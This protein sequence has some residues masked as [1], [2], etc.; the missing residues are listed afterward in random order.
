MTETEEILKRIKQITGHKNI[1]NLS[2]K[3]NVEYHGLK[4]GI[5]RERFQEKWAMEIG[6]R[7]KKCP[8]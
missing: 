5:D 7:Y 3:I 2:R 8:Y 6:R 4:K 1:K